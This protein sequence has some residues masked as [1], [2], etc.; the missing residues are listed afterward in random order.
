ML[1]TFEIAQVRINACASNMSARLTWFEG[2]DVQQGEET[3]EY[4]QHDLYSFQEAFHPEPRKM[5]HVVIRERRGGT[6]ATGR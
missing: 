2:K 5:K 6:L 4:H 1:S 3:Q